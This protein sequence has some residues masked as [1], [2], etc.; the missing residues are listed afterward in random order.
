MAG[1]AARSTAGRSRAGPVS[2]E[3]AAR[4]SNDRAGEYELRVSSRDGEDVREHK[5]RSDAK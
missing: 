5:A 3:P 1:A 4:P 2:S